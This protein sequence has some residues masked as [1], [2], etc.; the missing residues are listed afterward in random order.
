MLPIVYG[1]YRKTGSLTNICDANG[2]RTDMRSA[3]TLQVEL[4]GYRLWLEF[5][6]CKPI[7]TW[8]ILGT[9]FFDRLVENIGLKLKQVEL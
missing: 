9:D 8:R 4:G 1:T 3:V 6:F 5:V 2:N 7:E